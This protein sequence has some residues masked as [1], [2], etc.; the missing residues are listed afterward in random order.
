MNS[1]ISVKWNELFG[2]NQYKSTTK[3]ARNAPIAAYS[4]APVIRLKLAISG[5]YAHIHADKTDISW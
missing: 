3:N 2:T 4:Y 1:C 5:R